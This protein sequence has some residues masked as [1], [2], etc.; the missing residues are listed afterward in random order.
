MLS[1]MHIEVFR[2]RKRKE[3]DISRGENNHKQKFPGR[4][5]HE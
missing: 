4:K 2:E 1:E 5:E 3:K